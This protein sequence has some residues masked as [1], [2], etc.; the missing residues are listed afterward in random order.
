MTQSAAPSLSRTLDRKPDYSDHFEGPL[1]R[2]AETARD[3]A[4]VAVRDLPSWFAALFRVRQWIA[5][6]V[7]LET[8]ETTKFD[9]FLNGLEVI[10]DTKDSFVAGLPDRHLDFALVVTRADGRVAIDTLIWF[11]R[12]YGHL[13]LIAVLPFHRAILRHWIR[14]LGR[15]SQVED[16]A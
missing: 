9:G 14:V 4:E 5:A 13:Y 8:G 7:G 12:W 2:D 10:E 11:N 1:A 15:A 16:R 3:L 6:R